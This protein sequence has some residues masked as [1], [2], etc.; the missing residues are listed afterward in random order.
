VTATESPPAANSTSP[1]KASRVADAFARARAEGRTAIMPFATAG[2]PTPERSEE[3]VLAMVRGGADLIEIGVPFSDPL[4]D[5]ATV[6]RTSQVALRH[7]VTLAGA[8]AMVRRLREH[9][10]VSI[11]ILLMGY[12]NPMLQYGLDKLAR[13]SAA[14]GVDGFIVPD[15]PAEESDELLA[16]C[17]RHGLDLVFL[18]APTSTDERIAAVAERASGFI[19]CVSLRGVTGQRS[20]LPDL[21]DYLARVRARTD[22]PLA[23]GFGVSTPEHVRQVGEVADGAVVASALIDFL[24]TVPD[25]AQAVAAEQ[26]VRGLRGEAPF[27]PQVPLQATNHATVETDARHVQGESVPEPATTGHR[28]VACRGI[29]GA[30]TVET[31][32]SE[33]ILEATTDLLDA[34]IRL[35]DVAPEDVVSAIFTTTPEITASF[36]AMAARELGWTDVPL[37]CAHEMAV[38]GALRGV[39]RILLHIN[40]TRPPAEIRHVYLREAGALRPEWAYDDAQLAQIL[41]RVTAASETKA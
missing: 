21:H 19:Y 6:Q 12:Y 13:D 26:F 9:H 37:L 8:V 36:P 29:R 40:T 3:W 39:V 15:L 38:P 24:D 18:L 34:I 25:A 2:Y 7:G 11:P 4:A 23:I 31:N 33:D 22:V 30:T 10:G 1:A 20:A 14:A 5:G 32:T 41:G 16:V 17:R 27:P 35:N 28:Y